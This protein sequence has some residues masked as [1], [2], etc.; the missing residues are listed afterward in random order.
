MALDLVGV[1]ISAGAACSS[2][3]VARSPVLAAMGYSDA[4]ARSGVRVS[5]GWETA[6][7]DLNELAEIWRRT[8]SRI[9]AGEDAEAA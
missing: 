7:S 5:F 1:A 2:G 4:D 3:K 9:R 8:I 6:E